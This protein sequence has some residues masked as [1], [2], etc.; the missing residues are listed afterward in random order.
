MF[1]ESSNNFDKLIDAWTSA[2]LRGLI[3]ERRKACNDGNIGKVNE[4]SMQIRSEIK[5]S[6]FGF[7]DKIE[8]LILLV[9]ASFE[10]LIS[11]EVLQK[12]DNIF[13]VLSP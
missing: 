3:H 12:V 7:K 6:K 2:A 5:K 8:T 13:S 11:R 4:I 9:M 1:I 10:K